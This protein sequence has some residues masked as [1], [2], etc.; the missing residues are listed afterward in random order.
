MA[1]AILVLNAGS[2]SLKFS[3]FLDG[4]PPEPL[5]R[6]QLE[7]LFTAAALRGQRRGRQHWSG[8][9]AGR[10]AT[11]SG[12]DGAIEFLFAWGRGGALGGAPHRRGGPPRRPRRPEVHR[13]RC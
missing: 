1:D 7:G 4:E 6:G 12:H 9:R 13:S 10:P 3:V 8:R 11:S 5:L 2:S